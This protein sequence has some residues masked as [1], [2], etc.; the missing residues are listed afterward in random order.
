MMM[1]FKISVIKAWV[2]LCFCTVGKLD[3]FSW[4]QV[5]DRGIVFSEIKKGDKNKYIT[6]HTFDHPRR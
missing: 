5:N 6:R 3:L 4:S 2:E 1:A